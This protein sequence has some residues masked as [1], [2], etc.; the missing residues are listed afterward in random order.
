M[1]VRIVLVWASN[2]VAL[3]VADWWVDGIRIDEWWQAIIAGAVF[4]IINALVKPI[5]T[6]LALPVVIITLGVALFFVNL[7]MLVLT[8]WLMPDF[9]I[10]GFWPAVAGTIVVWLVNL[11][12]YAIFG[13]N[14]RD[15]R[16][17]S[18][19]SALS[20][21]AGGP[22]AG[23]PSWSGVRAPGSRR[24]SGGTYA[25][26]GWRRRAVVD[27]AVGGDRCA[28]ASSITRATSSTRSRSARCASMRSPTRTGCAGLAVRPLTF[29][30]PPR[31]AA[32]A[33]ERVLSSRTAQSH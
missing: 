14:D 1:L 15:R 21:C 3:L 4:G 29:T 28:D 20:A 13:L 19:L 33:S 31:H 6:L 10:D 30:C 12:V 27:E 2:T 7:L 24:N 17:S 32:A 9:H 5:V 18:P 23:G 8:A 11:V 25:S 16:T 26:R 22:A